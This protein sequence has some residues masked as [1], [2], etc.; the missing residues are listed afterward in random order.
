MNRSEGKY[1][2][3]DTEEDEDLG[4]VLSFRLKSNPVLCRD[5]LSFQVW[6]KLARSVPWLA[7]REV[8]RQLCCLES[9]P[10]VSPGHDPLALSH[11]LVDMHW[12]G[13]TSGFCSRDSSLSDLGMPQG[14]RALF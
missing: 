12:C 3:P 5:A 8:K 6:S 4:K 10:H 13:C 2:F 11:Q 7:M 9:T 1:G 14:A